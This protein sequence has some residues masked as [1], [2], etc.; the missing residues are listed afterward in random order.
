MQIQN[1]GGSVYGLGV[2]RFHTTLVPE[3]GRVSLKS[4]FF[5]QKYLD[6]AKESQ[7]RKKVFILSILIHAYFPLQAV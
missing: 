1:Q 7:G 6:G 2:P 4:L 5:Q 3:V